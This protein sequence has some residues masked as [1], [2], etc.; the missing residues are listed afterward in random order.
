MSS[1]ALEYPSSPWSRP[2]ASN[3][4]LQPCNFTLSALFFSFLDGH[5]FHLLTGTGTSTVGNRST[6]AE[7]SPLWH[8]FDICDGM[9]YFRTFM[10]RWML[11]DSHVSSFIECHVV[12]KKLMVKYKRKKTDI[13][14]LHFGFL[15]RWFI[16]LQKKGSYCLKTFRPVQ[17]LLCLF[18]VLFWCLRNLIPAYTLHSRK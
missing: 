10:L 4:P 8:R 6:G 15:L 18:F 14:K 12:R 3:G 17:K 5:F 7:N 16:T 2:S 11:T 1:L 9:T 13:R